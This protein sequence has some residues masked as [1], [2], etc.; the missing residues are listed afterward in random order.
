MLCN[1]FLEKYDEV[2]VTNF[3]RDIN[4]ILA[5]RRIVARLTGDLELQVRIQLGIKSN[6]GVQQVIKEL[7]SLQI[8]TLGIQEI[9]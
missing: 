4:L 9:E 1:R 7:R 3:L 6:F 5:I 8:R 2:G